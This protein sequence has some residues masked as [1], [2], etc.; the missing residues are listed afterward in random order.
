MWEG[1]NQKKGRE[2]SL[3]C[4]AIHPNQLHSFA[5]PSSQTHTA[6]AQRGAA[7]TSFCCAVSVYK[8]YFLSGSNLYSALSRE[9]SCTQWSYSWLKAEIMKEQE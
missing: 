7:Y 8:T 3:D 9:I 5:N 4:I 2:I 6:L 1:K